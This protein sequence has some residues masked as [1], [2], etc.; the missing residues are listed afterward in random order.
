[1]MLSIIATALVTVALKLAAPVLVPLVCA[2]FVLALLRP[3][4][5]RLAALGRAPV[6]VALLL[7]FLAGCAV[8]TLASA[9]S[10][11]RFA[12]EL[13]RYWPRVVADLRRAASW[14]DARA[15]PVPSEGEVVEAAQRLWDALGDSLLA[16]GGG[17]VL[18]TAFVALLSLEQPALSAKLAPAAEWR[19]VAERVARDVRRFL[20]VRGAVGLVA[21]VAVGVGC[22]A[23]GL[24]LPFVWALV[25]FL[26]SFVP[27]VG[28]VI[29]LVWPG[30]FAWA[31]LG[32][33][34]SVALVVGVVGGVQFL[35]ANLLAPIL[36]RRTLRIA[37]SA[38]L[39]SV[40]FWG[41]V[42]G[43]AGALLGVPLTIVVV[44][45]AAQFER[46]RWI[47]RLLATPGDVPG[48]QST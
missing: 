37:A 48:D 21:A 28:A 12:A 32:D 22:W 45:V 23:I 42:W 1:M 19:E 13:P 29:G 5:V 47:A 7:V 44:H 34:G 43:V 20:F 27:T 2:A 26:S 39:A 46:T 11:A 10:G 31:Q 4:E 38:V 14:A 40:L 30:L 6:A 25:N 36:H 8:F 9:A 35:T 17:F 41:F 16:L 24:E 15:L 18:V 33:V 3:L